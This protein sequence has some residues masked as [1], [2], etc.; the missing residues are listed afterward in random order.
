MID[1]VLVALNTVI[2]ALGLTGMIA[3]LVE[4]ISLGGETGFVGGAW[5]VEVD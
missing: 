5:V 2:E 1:V 3:G 4:L